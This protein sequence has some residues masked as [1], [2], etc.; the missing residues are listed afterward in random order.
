M[1]QLPERPP[2][3]RKHAA[4]R[5][6]AM[7]AIPIVLMAFTLGLAKV[8]PVSLGE[9]GWSIGLYLVLFL[10]GGIGLLVLFWRLSRPDIEKFLH[11]RV[12]EIEATRR[13]APEL[14]SERQAE[15]VEK[16]KT[17][18]AKGPQEKK[19]RSWVEWPV[20]ILLAVGLVAV[21]NGLEYGIER[22]L[23]DIPE[24][25]ESL[26]GFACGIGAII[27]LEW[28]KA[29]RNKKRGPLPSWRRIG[30]GAGIAVL[31]IVVGLIFVM[32]IQ[33]AVSWTFGQFEGKP[34]AAGT[35]VVFGGL[36]FALLLASL[37]LM[38]GVFTHRWVMSALRRTDYDTALR[39]AEWIARWLRSASPKALVLLHMDRLDE[40]EAAARASIQNARQSWSLA[41]MDRGWLLEIL[42]CTQ[43]EL[44][45]YEEAEAAFEAAIELS[46]RD[47]DRRTGLAEVY[48]RQGIEP[49]KALHWA[50][51]AFDNRYPPW[52]ALLGMRLTAAELR[53]NV[54]WALALAGQ[55]DAA[56]SELAQ[57]LDKIDRQARSVQASLH[58]R[59]G[60]ALALCGDAAAARSHFEQ[61]AALDPHGTYGRLARAA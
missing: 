9:S 48:L 42:G 10:A 39:R 35:V 53:A 15:A 30:L 40:A 20:L 31:V 54:A 45:R 36:G 5:L 2:E 3:S 7:L 33:Q 47:S 29:Q 8:I 1:N 19:R 26:M 21:W 24:S 17:G 46:H 32:G 37:A 14:V 58:V 52:I 41:E 18:V 43:L 28:F 13:V 61:A 38:P 60:R 50:R 34:L 57:A 6:L 59:A 51:Q 49:E 22:F 16:I 12:R 11:D 44:G 4:A 23:F 56:Q 55:P 27:L 25:V